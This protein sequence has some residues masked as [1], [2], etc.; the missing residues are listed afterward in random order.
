MKRN[1]LGVQ[2]Y[3]LF[4]STLAVV[5]LFAGKRLQTY[6]FERIEVAVRLLLLMTMATFYSRSH[7]LIRGNFIKDRNELDNAMHR[8]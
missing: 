8:L 1:M 2:K 6:F 4:L 3:I 7:G 5:T